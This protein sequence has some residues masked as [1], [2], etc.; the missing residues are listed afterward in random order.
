[1]RRLLAIGAIFAA[2]GQWSQAQASPALLKQHCAECHNADK[3]KG[4]FKLA[5]LGTAPNA[6]NFQ[7]WLDAAELV[8]AQE[9]PPE[10]G[11]NLTAAQ[12]K[13]LVA[14]FKNG[15]AKYQ[16]TVEL[17]LRNPP[18]RLNNREFVNSIADALLL[19]D[20]GTHQPAAD[21]IGDS[22]HH[23]FDTHGATLGMSK[24]HLEQ[25]VRTVRRIVAATILTGERPPVRRIE[26]PP[27]AIRS[28]HTSQN[29]TRPERRGRREGFDFLDP[30]Q[31]AYLEGF[32]TVPTTGHYKITVRA[33]GLDRRTYT[34]EKTG[35]HHG[36]PIRITARMGDRSRTF[37]LPDN[38]PRNIVLNEWLAVGTRFRLRYPT[39]GLTLRGN[40]NFKFQ[41]AIGGEH[42]KETDPKLWL[43]IAQGPKS[44]RN[45]GERRRPESWHNWVDHWQGPRPRLLSAT[46]EGPFYESWPP[47]R[48]VALLGKNPLA[49][50]AAAIL[51]P[52][53]ERAWRRP[54]RDGEL[55]SIVSLVQAKAAKLGDVEALK[56]G[57]VAVLVSPA[58][59]L[60]NT[61][62]LTPADR[63][64]A[65]FSYFLHSTLPDADL[66]AAVAAG[67]LDTLAGIRAELG[68]RLANGQAEPFLRAFP[69]AWLELNDINFMAP[70]PDRYRFYH[71][72]RLSEDM[73]D[74][75]LH[76]FRH[77]I[78]RNRPL[79]EFLSV[80]YSFI[81][82]DLAKL[83]EVPG[84]PADSTFRKH[85][86]T[87]GRRG[88][89]L[90]M[91]AFLTTTADSLATSPIHRAIYVMENFLGIHPA[92]PPA[93][94]EI[95]EPDV[96]QARTI[97]EILRAH[98]TDANCASC[99]RNIDPYGFAFEN[100]DP[101]G[102]WRDVYEITPR[103]A[104]KETVRLPIDASETFR[105]GNTYHDITG[106]RAALLTPANRDR[107]VRCF[108][109][110]ALTYANGTEPAKAHYAEIENIITHSARH[111]H[112]ILD[113][114]A[115]LIHSP[116]F[117]EAS[118]PT[119]R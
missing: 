64:A 21:L 100:F 115:A 85:I 93:D 104:G 81:N 28:E 119:A 25:Y 111:N 35:V 37:D 106:Y 69:Y 72:K 34:A 67:R 47:K 26:V 20:I 29:T 107:F 78:E 8:G 32:R 105:N 66:R 46:V 116:L 39:D 12:R 97:K 101:T 38:Q 99:H 53:A 23:G 7:R 75:A 57:L 103:E 114:L 42:I 2:L 73:I 96:R 16:A 5:D 58:F 95:E 60:L 74:E 54:V 108:I 117:R 87:D 19:E 41:Y 110:K 49:K 56:E 91:G 45:T 59:L 113:T 17:S 52:I 94:V 68:R 89:L 22:L 27:T 84:V 13:Q 48:Q 77:A 112:Q 102:A 61:D 40:G 76:F 14:Y 83:Y 3:A 43:E 15:L 31:L 118:P 82:A 90:G 65:K 71:R 24:F 6:A 86:F 33:T 9:M 50:N 55:K 36:D 63:F 92:P 44:R 109:T 79:P 88:G 70:D 98:R 18:R 1:M 80:N 11:G 51:R 62:D 4:K 10:D 30:K